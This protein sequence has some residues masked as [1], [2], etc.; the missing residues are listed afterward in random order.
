VHDSLPFLVKLIVAA[1]SPCGTSDSLVRP[2]DRWLSYVS[3][4]DRVVDR[5]RGA[6]LAHQIVWCTSDS[7]VNYSSGAISIFPR[8]TYSLERQS[9]HRTLSGA[10]WT[11][12]CTVGW[13]KFGWTEP[14]FSNP[15]SLNLT[16]FLALSEST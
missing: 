5:W 8:A 1:T 12:R 14:N 4:A 6:W 3:P 16:R 9:G 15:I 2:S 13:C 7:P 11:V 10:H